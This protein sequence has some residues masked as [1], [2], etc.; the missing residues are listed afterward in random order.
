MAVERML[1]LMYSSLIVKRYLFF[2]FFFLSRLTGD[3]L[4][5][6]FVFFVFFNKTSPPSPTSFLKV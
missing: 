1:G 3:F 6:F 4:L 2:F 5:G